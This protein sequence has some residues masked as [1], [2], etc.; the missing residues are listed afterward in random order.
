M[1]VSVGIDVAEE[2]KGLDLIALADDRSVVVMLDRATVADVAAV[3]VDLRPDV[4]CIDSP[5]AW[6]TSGRSR[7]AERELRAFGITAYATPT[8]PGQHPFYRW[9]RVGFSIFAAI[10][11]DYPRF[12]TGPVRSTAVEVFPEASAVLLRGCLRPAD[13]PKV[14][15]RRGVLADHRVDPAGLGTADSVDAAL[16]ALTGLLAL[17]GEFSTVGDAVEGVIVVPVRTLPSVRLVRPS[18][19]TS[20]LQRS[21]GSSSSTLRDMNEVERAAGLAPT[22]SYRYADVVGDRLYLA[23]Q[24]PL[25]ADGALSGAGDVRAQTQQCLANLF[26]IVGAHGFARDDIH[27]LTIY[28]VGPHRNL[29]DAWAEVTAGFASNVPPATLLGVNLLG[30]RNQLVE[31][32]ARVERAT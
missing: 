9:M 13:E 15:F 6:A 20:E 1:S 10:A 5:P 8:D 26:A 31:I 2:R 24:V 18:S 27:H 7:A 14:R 16:A 23:G 32:D 21:G 29:L 11:D 25:D 19:V 30:Y 4:V 12:R 22:A 17:E 3:I 28:V